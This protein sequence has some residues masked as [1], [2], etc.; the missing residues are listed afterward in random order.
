MDTDLK[1]LSM[2]YNEKS[3]FH[4]N[5]KDEVYEKLMTIWTTHGFEI[6]VFDISTE[7]D[8]QTLMKK[9]YQRHAQYSKPGVIVAAGGDGT[10]NAVA[11]QMLHQNIPMTIREK[12]EKASDVYSFGADKVIVYS[13]KPKLT[14]A[15]DGEIV[16]MDTPLNLHVEK[17]ALNI[18]VPAHAAT[19]I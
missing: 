1:P 7:G 3:G 4:A 14:V 17:N 2:I 12:L 6:Q 15:I 11:S 8:I 18:M 19:S 13:K 16:S 5:H 10:L 9:I